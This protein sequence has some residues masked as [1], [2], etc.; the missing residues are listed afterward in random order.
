[1]LCNCVQNQ[2]LTQEDILRAK[3]KYQS[4]KVERIFDLI[5]A[6]NNEKLPASTRESAIIAIGETNDPVGLSAIVGQLPNFAKTNLQMSKTAL[7]VLSASGNREYSL[8]VV[9]SL[10]EIRLAYLDLRNTLISSLQSIPDDEIIIPLIEILEYSKEDYF[11]VQTSISEIL[12]S[13]DD[14]RV[15]PIL[16]SIATDETV[17]TSV[18][19]RVIEMLAK[20]EDPVVADAFADLLSDP[21][22]QISVRDFALKSIEDVSDERI[23]L[24]LMEAHQQNKK[25]YYSLLDALVGA[26]ADFQDVRA[27]PTL[28]DIV[29]DGEAPANIRKSAV[30]KLSLVADQPVIDELIALMQN[31]DNYF[32]YPP[33]EKLIRSKGTENDLQ[34]LRLAAL[35]AHKTTLGDK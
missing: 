34:Q 32:L 24:A 8:A 15:V 4:G 13:M 1:M 33:V 3:V 18:R 31:R 21:E 28:L 9:A 22:S 16:I 25:D 10:G 2:L 17:N 27:I 6:M 12:G 19:N 5:A 20:K 26:L 23:I 35:M 14:Q 11:S 7:E 29:K 30:E